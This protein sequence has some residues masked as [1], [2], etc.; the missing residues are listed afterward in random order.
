MQI[1]KVVLKCVIWSCYCLLSFF[2]FRKWANRRKSW[3]D[4]CVVLNDQRIET[5]LAE[6]TTYVTSRPITR[7]ADDSLSNRGA[8]LVSRP[9]YVWGWG[10]SA[11]KR[12]IFYT[13]VGGVHGES[14][15]N[16]F[17]VVS[18]GVSLLLLACMSCSVWRSAWASAPDD[19]TRAQ[20]ICVLSLLCKSAANR[21]RISLIWLD[22]TN[23]MW[24]DLI[25]KAFICRAV[26]YT[27]EQLATLI[28]FARLHTHLPS[29][30]WA[31]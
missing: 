6:T 15:T 4:P 22:R 29:P 16:A 25:K 17:F 24:V 27:P 1:N 5:R 23:R 21:N 31:S 11:G 30:G 2:F 26:F 3:K 13:L 10:D 18:P 14:P 12:I 19:L 9:A 20:L 28:T 7:Y 8:L